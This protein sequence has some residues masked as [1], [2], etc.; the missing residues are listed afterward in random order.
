MMHNG[1]HA[2][3]G[4]SSS[5]GVNDVWLTTGECAQI[6]ERLKKAMAKTAAA[7]PLQ[8]Q[9]GAVLGDQAASAKAPGY[10]GDVEMQ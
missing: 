10:E 1:S 7:Q 2:C 9:A 4:Q 8:N 6:A 3:G 5:S